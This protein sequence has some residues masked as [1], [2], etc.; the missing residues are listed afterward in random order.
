[1]VRLILRDVAWKGRG[2]G[3]RRGEGDREEGRGIGKEIG[4]NGEVREDVGEIERDRN[5]RG[6]EIWKSRGM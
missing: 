5:E 4:D 6:D 1:M 2:I 3:R